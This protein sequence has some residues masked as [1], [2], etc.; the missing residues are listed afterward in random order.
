MKKIMKKFGF[1][2]VCMMAVV[3][4]FADVDCTIIERIGNILYY[5]RIAAFIGA[6]FYIAAWAWDFIKGGEAKMDD[7]KKRGVALLVGFG[8]LIMVGTIITFVM[9]TTGFEKCKEQLRNMG[10]KEVPITTTVQ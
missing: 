6:A 1:A 8:L 4:A 5:L 3:P 9:S 7:I 10:M 2:L